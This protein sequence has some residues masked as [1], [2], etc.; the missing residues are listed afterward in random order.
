MADKE[1]I[2][3]ATLD[4][5][6][7]QKDQPPESPET[8]EK[9]VEQ[10]PEKAPSLESEPAPEKLGATPQVE[11]VGADAPADVPEAEKPEIEESPAAVAVEQIE[12]HALDEQRVVTE[13]E[14]APVANEEPA[15]G[16]G[17]EQEEV[18]SN[19]PLDVFDEVASGDG[20]VSDPSERSAAED[21]KDEAGED[22]AAGQVIEKPEPVEG[23]PAASGDPDAGNPVKPAPE[24]L[25]SVES[26]DGDVSDPS[27]TGDA[28][29]TGPVRE[30]P[31]QIEL[32]DSGDGDVSDPSRKGDADGNGPSTSIGEEV[33]QLA[34]GDGDVS[35]PSKVDEAGAIDPAFPEPVVDDTRSSGDGDASDLPGR[36]I[37]MLGIRSS[38]PRN[39]S[40][41]SQPVTL[42]APIRFGRHPQWSC[43]PIPA[44]ATPAILRNAAMPGIPNPQRASKI[45]FPPV[46]RMPV[47]R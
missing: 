5:A 2:K 16:A 45:S 30:N 18:D 41:S 25:Q 24:E 8:P 9:D 23:K 43:R 11:K 1:T 38:R 7:T 14:K 12:T 37:Q 35:D 26:G 21:S 10:V 6:E 22:E 46:T 3:E 36:A 15:K 20:D 42:K 33:D 19:Q 31:N 29:G 27:K 32:Q 44:M 34:S 4:K 17:N 28:D 40:T 13:G 39:T 47:T